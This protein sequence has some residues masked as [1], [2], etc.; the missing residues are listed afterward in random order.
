VAIPC[1]RVIGSDRTLVGY[2]GGLERKES[3][4]EF[5]GFPVQKK[6]I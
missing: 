6:L 1:H 4:L 5:E 2:S 3:I